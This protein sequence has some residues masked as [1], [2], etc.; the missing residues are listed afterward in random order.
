MTNKH[1]EANEMSNGYN[2]WTNY[3][4]WRVNLE[5]LDGMT[6][7]HFGFTPDCL[8]T[9]DYSAVEKFAGVLEMYVCEIIEQ[10]ATGFALDLARSFL[11]HVDWVQIAEH[12]LED[13]KQEL[14]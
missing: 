10:D 11:A 3:E 4:T 2:G 6:L 13:A 1:K 12:M 9:D 5:I 8:D 7:G 14:V